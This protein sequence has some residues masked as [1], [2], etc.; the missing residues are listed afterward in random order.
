VSLTGPDFWPG[1]STVLITANGEACFYCGAPVEDPAVTWHGAT[2][3]IWL[4][5]GCVVDLFTRLARDLWEF[6]RCTG[7]RFGP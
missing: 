1:A 6:Q 2:G 5:I 3:E 4:H 7:R